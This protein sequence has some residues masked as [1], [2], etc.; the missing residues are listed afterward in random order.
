MEI[1]FLNWKHLY[2][3]LEEVA[4]NSAM[5]NEVTG[6]RNIELFKLASYADRLHRIYL[7]H[8]DAGY[9]YAK[10]NTLESLDN[11]FRDYRE[12][13]DLELFSAV[14]EHARKSMRTE[15]L[16]AGIPVNLRSDDYEAW[17]QAVFSQ[18][19]LTNHEKF[20]EAIQNGGA[21]FSS[22]LEAD[23]AY[24]IYIAF[25]E[26][27]KNKLSLYSNL[28]YDQ[29]NPLQSDYVTALME[30]YPDRRF[31]PDGNST[32]RVTYGQVEGLSP[33]DGLMYKTQTYLEG[34]M[35]KYVPGDYEFDVPPRLITLY[36]SKDYGIYGENGK[37]PVR[38]YCLQ[39]HHKWK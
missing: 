35:E 28:L 26:I 33:K 12:N 10:T 24:Q 18:T 32:M 27:N 15:Y 30:V 23:T 1:S 34:V 11:Y 2:M 38:I 22:W 5:L 8:G 4:R 14:M 19:M 29:I 25:Q 36:E 20:A 16:P 31:W 39:S 13:I 17:A 9:D 37:M 3:D 6:G 7:N 21:A